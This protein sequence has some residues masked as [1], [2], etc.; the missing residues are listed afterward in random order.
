MPEETESVISAIEINVLVI[1]DA[2]FS[3]YKVK[4]VEE[5]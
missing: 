2:L 4:L 5:G 3:D 1:L